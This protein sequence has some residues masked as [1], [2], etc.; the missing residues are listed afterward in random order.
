MPK[1]VEPGR[2]VKALGVVA[3]VRH[4]PGAIH[5]EWRKVQP[6]TGATHPRSRAASASRSAAPGEQRDQVAGF[7]EQSA[8]RGSMRMAPSGRSASRATCGTT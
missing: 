2:A 4:S 7:A 6:W 3:A 1:Q 8:E 5:G